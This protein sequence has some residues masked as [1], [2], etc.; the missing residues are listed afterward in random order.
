[1]LSPPLEPR[2]FLLPAMAGYSLNP[3]SCVLSNL[4][5][6]VTLWP[7]RAFFP[8]NKPNLNPPLTNKQSTT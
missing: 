8:P 5:D 3:V 6:S 7:K 2:N 4:G 1:M